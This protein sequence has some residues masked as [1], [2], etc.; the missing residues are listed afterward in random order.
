MSISYSV[1]PLSNLNESNTKQRLKSSSEPV[2]RV[3][4]DWNDIT[5]DDVTTESNSQD[6]ENELIM[7]WLQP[8]DLV[9]FSP[10]T[11]RYKKH[12]KPSVTSSNASVIY[13]YTRNPSE[14]TQST[15]EAI[16]ETQHKHKEKKV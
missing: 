13:L 10:V 2:K 14:T 9:T 7:Q 15:L 6:S 1:P 12:R 16:G 4:A 3:F 11:N 8:V 5:K